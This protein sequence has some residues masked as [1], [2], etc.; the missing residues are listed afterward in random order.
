MLPQF[1]NE[2]NK[3]IDWENMNKGLYM[4]AIGLAKKVALADVIAVYANIGFNNPDSLN[5]IT[6][7][8]SSI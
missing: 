8:L 1:E 2:K 5:I 6:S 3:I 4:F 7:W